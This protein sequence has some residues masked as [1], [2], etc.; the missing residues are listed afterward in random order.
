MYS[1][2]K[3]I[4]KSKQKYIEYFGQTFI[5]SLLLSMFIAAILIQPQT[6]GFTVQF[7]GRPVM[8]TGIPVVTT[9]MSVNIGLYLTTITILTTLFMCMAFFLG[10]L[11]VSIKNLRQ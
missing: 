10:L 9:V 7:V 3:L 4:N 8:E 5:L 6:S 2:R 1:T 11:F